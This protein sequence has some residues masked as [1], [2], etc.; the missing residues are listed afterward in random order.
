MCFI[1]RVNVTCKG[2]KIVISQCYHL[3]S[4]SSNM[5]IIYIYIYIHRDMYLYLIIN[6]WITIA[7]G[8]VKG[9]RACEYV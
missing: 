1:S 7:C 8:D 3:F 2:L 9:S 4:I 6:S 5:Y